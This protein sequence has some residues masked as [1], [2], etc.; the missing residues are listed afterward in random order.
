MFKIMKSGLKFIGTS[1]VQ[2]SKK[3]VFYATKEE[4]TKISPETIINFNAIKEV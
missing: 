2:E 3:N 1:N 4:L